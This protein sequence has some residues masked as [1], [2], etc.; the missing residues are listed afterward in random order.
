MDFKFSISVKE[1][2]VDNGK[3][4]MDTVLAGLVMIE[5]DG[6]GGNVSRG[7]G[8]V[9]FEEVRIINEKELEDDWREKALRKLEELRKRG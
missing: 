2:D 8:Q 6:L 9:K 4:H 7:C 3:N 1:F 5:Q